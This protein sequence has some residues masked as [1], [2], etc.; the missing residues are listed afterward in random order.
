VRAFTRNQEV[1]SPLCFEP[2]DGAKVEYAPGER[3]RFGF[4]V[5]D[6]AAE[7]MPY[8]IYRVLEVDREA[9]VWGRY[10]RRHP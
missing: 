3:M 7:H 4:I 9:T 5:V 8:F 6:Q 2:P 10:E 1:P